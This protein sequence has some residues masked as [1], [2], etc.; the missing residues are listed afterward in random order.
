VE[1][2]IQEAICHEHDVVA[3]VP[4]PPGGATGVDDAV[5]LALQR[6]RDADVETRWST[7]VWTRAP[8]EPLPTDSEWSG[9]VVYI[10]K[11]EMDVR[12]SPEALWRVIIG[13]G[14]ETGWYS[15]PLAWTA[16]G[17]LDRLIGGVG[18]QR[19]RRDPHQLH[20]GEALDFWRVEAIDPGRMLRLRAE[21]RLP[22]RAWLEMTVADGP[23]GCLYRQRAVFLP[24]G[25]AGPLYWRS[26]SPFHA[27][28][29]GGMARNIAR[30][31]ERT[32]KMLTEADR[33]NSVA[34]NLQGSASARGRTRGR[35]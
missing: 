24:R 3:Y 22:G 14:G 17:W 35:T 34:G 25:L 6:T 23:A 29:F 16:R 18:L 15:F 31:A 33:A 32:D 30:I 20:V 1:G 9:G 5:R 26:I 27:I 13:I 2:L 12:A 7:A 19:G 10:D 28:V 8:A 21:M 11:R 4:D